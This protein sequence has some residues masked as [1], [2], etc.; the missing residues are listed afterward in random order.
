MQGNKV[1]LVACDWRG[2]VEKVE[3]NAI[4]MVSPDQLDCETFDVELVLPRQVATQE[5]TISRS[6]TIIL[7]TAIDLAE[8]EDR[9]PDLLLRAL[10]RQTRAIIRRP[11]MQ[12]RAVAT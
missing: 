8:M 1:M 6:N 11:H 5:M 3:F 12:E 9:L 4:G 10:N 2:D 7:T